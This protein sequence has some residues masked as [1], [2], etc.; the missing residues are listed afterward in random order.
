LLAEASRPNIVLIMA[1]DFGYECVTANGG[2]SYQTPHLDKLAATGM[3]FE[4]C[5]VQPLCTPTRVQLMTGVYNVR[6]Y[7]SFGKIGRDATTFAHLLKDA[8]YATG[9]AGKWQLGRAKGLPRRLGFDEAC[10]WQHTR[11]PPR[12]ANPGLEYDGEERDFSSGEYGPDLVNDFALDFIARHK[13]GPFFLY[14]PMMLTHGPFQPTPD[15]ADWDPAARGERVGRDV[16]HFAEMVAYADK[17]VGKLVARLD[18]L[19]IRDNTLVLFLGDNGTG[20]G[21]TSQFKGKPYRGGKGLT[22]VAGMHVPLVVNWPGRIAAGGVNGDLIASTDFLPTLCEASGAK[23]PTSLPPD[24]QSFYPQLAGQGGAPRQWL[25]S[26]F[27]KGQGL[28]QVREFAMTKQ[29]KL[30]RGGRF[31]DLVADPLE[32]SPRQVSELTGAEAEAA[33]QLAAALDE[34]ADARPPEVQAAA[35]AASRD[36]GRRPRRERRRGQRRRAAA[37]D[38]AHA[39][40]PNVVFI[41]ADDLGYADLGCYGS[42]YYETPH[43]DGMAG[44]G[45]RFTDGYACG[46]NCQ[47]TRAALMSGQYG[48]RTG[49]YTVGDINRFDWQS[50]PLRPVDNVTALPLEKVTVAQTLKNAGYA[51]AMFGKWHLGNKPTHHPSRRGFDEAIATAGQHFDFKTDPPVEVAPGAYLADFLTDRA[52][53]FIRRQRDKPFFLYLPHFGVHAPHEAKPE[54]VEHFRTKAAVGGQH[55]PT[56]AAMIAS[57]DESVGRILATLDEHGLAENTLVIFSSDNG[58]VGGYRR[59]GLEKDGVTDNAP[60]R[61]GKGMLAEGGVRVP[62]VFRWK[63]KIAPGR[64]EATPIIS[65]DLYPTLVELA[66]ATPPA[67]QPLDGVSCAALL[68]E[69]KPLAREAIFWHFP[70]YL[71]AGRGLWRT[72]PGGAVRV[73]DWK[74]IE[75]FEDGGLELYNLKDDVG[76]QHNLAASETEMAQRL[77]E[78]LN[79]WRKTVNA[80]MPTANADPQERSGGQPLK[81]NRQRN[82]ARAA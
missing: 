34:Y 35:G 43:I 79:A 24:G 41:L 12:Y 57:V 42:K 59:A 61:G 26:W 23:L 27:A 39:D 80:P 72:T 33:R 70:G 75:Y 40:R 69:G 74:L 19:G 68:T 62:Y 51:T 54:L 49:V 65:V 73:G 50:R 17:L 20:Q 3:R 82:R 60:L 67:D 52:V 46:P 58:G 5:Y 81:K 47:P 48:P 18:E 7:F 16:N 15:S 53:D 4:H 1:D 66:G 30:Y 10:L 44:E 56:Y 36:E 28:S 38:A 64:M 32:K 63:G 21:V 45:V 8:G 55:D 13:E 29:H 78:K 22:T 14:Y 9:I 77:R 76:E 37:R 6:N 31:F 11:R 71:G 2:Q 25:Y